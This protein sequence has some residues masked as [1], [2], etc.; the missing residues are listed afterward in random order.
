M[1]VLG[2]DF[3]GGA[4]KA[5]LIDKNG[6]VIA[7]A[8]TEYPTFYGENGKALS[9][10][11]KV[12]LA[13]PTE[14]NHED[15]RVVYYVGAEKIYVKSQY[16]DGKIRFNLNTGCHYSYILEVFPSLVSVLPQ[17]I[18]VVVDKEEALP[19]EIVSVNVNLPVGTELVSIYY[20][21]S[22]GVRVTINDGKFSMPAFDV[23]QLSSV[24]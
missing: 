20:I 18:K 3:G 10:S 8:T 16:S 9:S 17:E 4:S 12:S 11:F 23:S 1:Y 2:V 24:R 21:N 14:K 7:T 19:G 5:T 15:M 13:V 6:K 22:D